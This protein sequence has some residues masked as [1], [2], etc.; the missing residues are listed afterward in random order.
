MASMGLAEPPAPALNDPLDDVFG[1]DD[2]PPDTESLAPPNPRPRAQHHPSDLLRLQQQHVTAG[3]RD[4]VTA[5]K[6]ESV[7]V[8][9]DEGFSLGAVIGGKAGELLGLLEG[10]SRAQPDAPQLS[11]LLADATKELGIRS[12]FAPEYWAADGTW[13]YEVVAAEGESE[14]VFADVASAHPLIRKWAT[15]VDEQVARWGIDRAV[16]SIADEERE[17]TTTTEKPAKVEE[18]QPRQADALQ[19]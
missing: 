15:I 8:G 2:A 6:A 18:A 3:Y 14:V 5:A 16:L 1:S 4:G 12:V 13:T 7:Q 11:T 10:I 9:F 19:W 17:G